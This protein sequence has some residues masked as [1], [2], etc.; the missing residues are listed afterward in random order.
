[1]ST[2]T[3]TLKAKI[4]FVDDEQFILDGI[5]R[6]LHAKYDLHVALGGVKGLE[7]LRSGTP[8][9]VIV[10]DMRMP[11]M[12]G[13][14]FLNRAKEINPSAILMML[15]GN[16]DRQTAKD[17]VDLGHVFHFLT[18]PCSDSELSKAIDGGIDLFQLEEKINKIEHFSLKTA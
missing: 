4:L 11:E 6:Q 18:K 16:S 17:A 14:E 12:D 15:T 8:F 2:T 1:M 3:P 5:R 10:A 13:I 7:I 9:Q